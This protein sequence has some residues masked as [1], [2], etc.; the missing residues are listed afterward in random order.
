ML[1]PSC[2]LPRTTNILSAYASATNFNLKQD[3]GRKHVH[4]ADNLEVHAYSP[5]TIL[6]SASSKLRTPSDNR[7]ASLPPFESRWDHGLTTSIHRTLPLPPM[8]NHVS[9]YR[10]AGF[11]PSPILVP[12]GYVLVGPPTPLIPI[13]YPTPVLVPSPTPALPAIH[14]AL[15]RPPF[16]WDVRTTA[17]PTT[18]TRDQPARS[19]PA[20]FP[21]LASVTLRFTTPHGAAFAY[22]VAGAGGAALRVVDVLRAIHAA[23]Y[24]RADQPRD[25]VVLR[26]AKVAKGYRALKRDCGLHRVDLYPVSP[27]RV[28]GARLNFVGLEWGEVRGEVRVLLGR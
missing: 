12:Q 14:P 11:V 5:G 6:S 19:E 2:T 1:S 3:H 8:S 15:A 17:L 24:T 18:L 13:R 9:P 21:P 27:N 22:T 4:F 26:A 7:Y 25:A 23:L 20:F 16:Q 28:D 10:V